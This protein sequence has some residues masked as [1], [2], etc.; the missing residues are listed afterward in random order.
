MSSVL[1]KKVE[2]PLWVL[3][4]LLVIALAGILK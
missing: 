2:I 4:V 1:E 3:L